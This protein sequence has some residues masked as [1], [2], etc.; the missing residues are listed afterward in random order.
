VKKLSNRF[1]VLAVPIDACT[2]ANVI[3]KSE[4]WI[5]DKQC[6]HFIVFNNANGIVLASQ[7][8]S[9]RRAAVEAD[10]SV[11]DGMPLVW[12]G[13][14]KG[15]PIRRRVYGPEF[16]LEF[17]QQTEKK[18]YRH[19]FYGGHTGVPEKVTQSLKE[20]FPGIVIAGCYS[21]PFRPLTPEEE[22]VIERMINESRADILW[23][24]LGAPK[25]E[26]WMEQH[27][28]RLEVPVMAGVGAAFDFLAG[29]VSQAPLWMRENG[30]EWLYRLCREPR[31]LWRRYLVYNSLFL[32]YLFLEK[33]GLRKFE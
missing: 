9:F 6:S 31:R 22:A 14:W 13:R 8:Q 30:L 10:L 29:R 27:R 21:P 32:Y 12:L 7:N 33:T 18:G 25:Q 17:C 4:E 5:C 28:R 19:F 11:P 2:I 3:A 16:L 15:F 24:G 23:V 26:I 20:K 1:Y